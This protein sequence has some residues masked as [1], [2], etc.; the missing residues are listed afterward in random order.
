MLAGRCRSPW[1]RSSVSILERKMMD[2]LSKIAWK[3]VDY[4]VTL[5]TLIVLAVAVAAAL[6]LAVRVFNL[7]AGLGGC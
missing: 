3:I 1:R 2:K 7:M 6:G 5:F 4:V